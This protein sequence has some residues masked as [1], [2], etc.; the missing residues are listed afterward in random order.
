MDFTSYTN[1][2]PFA[3]SDKNKNVYDAYWTEELRIFN[4]FKDDLFAELKIMGHPEAE[5]IFDEAWILGFR[6]GYKEIFRQARKIRN[7]KFDNLIDIA[8]MQ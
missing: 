3:T 5:K 8:D 1:W 6:Q 4:K 7:K 2:K